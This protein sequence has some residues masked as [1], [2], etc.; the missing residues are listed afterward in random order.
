MTVEIRPLSRQ[1]L[2]DAGKCDPSFRIESEL[3]LEA[4]DGVISY[5]IRP[6]PPRTKRY[7]HSDERDVA[8]FI[9]APD[10]S[11]FLAYVDDRVAGHASISVNWNRYALLD[12]VEVDAG[13]RRLGVGCALV[14][15]AIGWARER[16]L[17]GIML[18]T[19]NNNVAACKLYE[20]MGFTLGG[21]DTCLYRGEMPDTHEIALFWYLMLPPADRHPAD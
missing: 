3:V 6:V 14:T 1:N 16:Q 19:Q 21:F 13:H 9:D 15:H 12:H 20:A 10:K 17:P 18:E 4:R 11:F 7:A 8:P 5:E 2:E